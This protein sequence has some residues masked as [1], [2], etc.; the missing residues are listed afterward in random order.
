MTCQL[1]QIYEETDTG[2]GA[3][4]IRSWAQVCLLQLRA[5]V[6]TGCGPTGRDAFAPDGSVDS[7]DD[8]D[9]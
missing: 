1:E 2:L 5:Q 3:V 7:D 6:L 8:A 4:K 9:Y